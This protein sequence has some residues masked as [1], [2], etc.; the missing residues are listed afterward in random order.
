MAGASLAAGVQCNHIA[1]RSKQPEQGLRSQ[2][3]V[4][5]DL[6]KASEFVGQACSWGQPLSKPRKNGGQKAAVFSSGYSSCRRFVKIGKLSSSGH[7][8]IV[9]SISV[10]IPV[11]G[12]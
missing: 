5:A 11:Q 3:I 6:Q 7:E 1:A 10:A 8:T 9:T 12:M 2:E 4:G